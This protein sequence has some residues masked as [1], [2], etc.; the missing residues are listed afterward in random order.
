MDEKYIQ[1]AFETVVTPE[2]LARI[3][4]FARYAKKYAT[5][6]IDGKTRGHALKEIPPQFNDIAQLHL[7]PSQTQIVSRRAMQA[8]YDN[9]VKIDIPHIDEP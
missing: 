5:E 1:Y 3:L 7:S 8:Y 4:E 6:K 9:Y 2:I